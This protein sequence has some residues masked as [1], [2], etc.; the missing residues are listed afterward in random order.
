[1]VVV[2][3]KLNKRAKIILVVLILALVTLVVVAIMAGGKNEPV[4]DGADTAAR[5]QFLNQYGYTGEGEVFSEITLPAEFDGSYEIYNA[6]QIEQGYNL[7][8]FAGQRAEL[9]TYKIT[10][11]EYDGEVNAHLLVL[12][13]R[14]IGGDISSAEL[15]GFL[16]GIVKVTQ[17]YNNVNVIAG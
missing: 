2:N 9:Y 8:K 3:F 11:Y 1:M 5:M 6:I 16:H 17:T 4:R 12:D 13:G 10:D 7:K 15:G 14:I